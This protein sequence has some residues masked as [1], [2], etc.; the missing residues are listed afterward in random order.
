MAKLETPPSVEQILEN[1]H[2]LSDQEQ[3]ALAAAVLNDRGLEAFVEELDDQLDCEKAA[4]EGPAE[5]FCS[6]TLPS[7]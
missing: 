1:I 3:R 6:E 7:P 5:P 2:Q 4:E